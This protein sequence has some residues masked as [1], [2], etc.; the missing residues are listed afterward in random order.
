VENQPIVY[1]EDSVGDAEL[2][3]RALLQMRPKSNLI[4]IRDGQAAKTYLATAERPELIA[5]D[6]NLPGLGGKELIRWIREQ[7]TMRT[8][9]VIALSGSQQAFKTIDEA[10]EIGANVFILKPPDYNGW[11][12]LLYQ[13]EDFLV[14]T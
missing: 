10:E 3:R 12:D 11:I 1:V 2:F 6:I 13:I 4:H 8:V 9:P 14:P 5:V 7:E